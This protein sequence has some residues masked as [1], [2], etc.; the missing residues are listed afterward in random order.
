MAYPTQSAD[1]AV[2]EVDRLA[3]NI[4]QFAIRRVAGMQAGDTASTTIFDTAIQIRQARLR[5]ATLAETPGIE[6]RARAKK[7]NDTLDVV[8]AF[9]AMLGSMDAVVQWV[10]DNFPKDSE[11][12]LLSQTMGQNGPIDRQFTPVETA[13]LRTQ[14]ENLI[15][16]ID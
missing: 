13:T 7:D 6:S 3:A 4:K 2:D 11:G 16:T 1:L 10:V 8:A 14:L 12:F 5:L 9:N 15:G